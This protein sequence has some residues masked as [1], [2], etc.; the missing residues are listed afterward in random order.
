MEALFPLWG[1][2]TA[3]LAHDFLR[4]GF[5][6]VL[7]CIDTQA[8]AP[9]FAGRAFDNSL[10]ND[11]PPGVDPCGENGEFHTFVH[12]GPIFRA[13]IPVRIGEREDRGRF[14]YCDLV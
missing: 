8:L 2:P 10:L 5:A 1:R 6:A 4:L 14:V 11:L 13:S 3:D 7:V 12:A 9:A